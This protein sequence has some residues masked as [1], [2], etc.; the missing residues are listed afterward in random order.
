MRNLAV[1]CLFLLASDAWADPGHDLFTGQSEDMAGDADLAQLQRFPCHSCHGRDGMGGLE[2]GAPAIDWPS[3]SQPTAERPGYTPETFHQAIATGIDP[4]GRELSR[5]MPRYAL[6][7]TEAEAVQLYLERLPEQQR[8]GVEPDRVRIGIAEIA[9]QERL[10]KAYREALEQALVQRLGGQQV[11]RRLVEVVGAKLGEAASEEVLAIVAAPADAVT[12]IARTGMPVLFP[13][14]PLEGD[15]DRTIVR[16]LSPTMRDVRSSL[17]TAITARDPQSVTIWAGAG[18][19]AEAM[20]EALRFESAALKITVTRELNKGGTG[21]LVILGNL[22]PHNQAQWNRV[23]AGW[24]LLSSGAP[25]PAASES[26]AVIDTPALLKAALS[27]SRHPLLIHAQFAGMALAEALK[28]A[29][30]TL[31]RASLV[32]ALDESMLLDIGLDYDTNPLSG[33]ATV[34]IVPVRSMLDR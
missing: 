32:A 27:E 19:E 34:L 22:P 33:T 11:Y 12:A 9:G 5:L 18:D 23:W 1:A 21:D 15:E 29:G 30:R 31:T 16:A 7:E 8:R 26:M 3:L 4:S 20:A 10:S 13:I 17:V 2:G 6:D 14:G 24:G 25:L 28:T